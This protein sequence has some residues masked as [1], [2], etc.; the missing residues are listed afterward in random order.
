MKELINQ[1]SGLIG[2]GI[3]AA[4]CLGIPAVLAAVSAAGLG[5]LLYDPYLFPLFVGF[6]A[7]S[8][9]TLFRST[10][11]HGALAPFWLG[12]GG[13][14]V[15]TVALWLL[16]SGA[17]PADKFIY[18]GLGAL[19]AGSV[20]NA[21]NARRQAA[22]ATGAVCEV[23]APQSTTS[24][25]RRR[26]TQAVSAL[27]GSGALFGMYKAAEIYSPVAQA[28]ADGETEKC[29]GV[30]KA[31]M[32]DCSTST[33]GCNGQATVDNAPDDF[34]FVPK[35]TCLKIGGKLKKA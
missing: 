25:A 12:L 24:V 14:V 29:F 13:G 9:W 10:R 23:E 17:Y 27:V 33:H 15:G 19:V 32:N 31:D 5:F 30:A 35:G 8:L 16:I 6:V 26:A 21:I 7:F 28:R 1:F 11:S 18:V 34:N 20:W 4:C 2:A 22:C 3:T